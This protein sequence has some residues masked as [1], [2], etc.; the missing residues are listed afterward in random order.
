MFCGLVPVLLSLPTKSLSDTTGTRHSLHY[1]GKVLLASENVKAC[2]GIAPWGFHT[3]RFELSG[4]TV[5][6]C[7][8]FVEAS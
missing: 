2:L 1:F 6:A 7:T 8:L 4:F 5:G 3:L